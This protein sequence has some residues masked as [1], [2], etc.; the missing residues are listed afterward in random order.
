MPLHIVDVSRYQVDG[1]GNILD[2]RNIPDLDG[3]I[4]GVTFGC[5]GANPTWKD[6][7]NNALD[8]PRD[9]VIGFYHIRNRTPNS[10]ADEAQFFLNELATHPRINEK[11]FTVHMDSEEHPDGTDVVEWVYEWNEYIAARRAYP[12]TYVGEQGPNSVNVLNWDKVAQ[13]SSLWGAQYDYSTPEQGWDDN[14]QLL[15]SFAYPVEWNDQGV[16]TSWK[17]WPTVAGH[18]YSSTTYFDGMGPFDV[19]LFFE[20]KDDWYKYA[21]ALAPTAT[22]EVPSP[23]IVA[24]P[25]YTPPAPEQIPSP[26]QCIVSPGDTLSSIAQQFN[27]SVQAILGVNNIADPNLIYA[28]QVLNLP[29]TSGAP[30]GTVYIVQSGDTLSGIAANYGTDYQTLAN[31]NGIAD[32]NVISVGQ[33]IRIP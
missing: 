12:L 5:S 33:Q 13:K 26:N 16:A 32:P 9:L 2:T 30:S 20:T 31:Y 3:V 10:P 29:S 25:A 15:G 27:T 28:G 17:Q 19:S 21:G 8:D 7:L 24:P 6:Q 11:P 14:R 18:Q 23:V 4:I 1:H 22:P